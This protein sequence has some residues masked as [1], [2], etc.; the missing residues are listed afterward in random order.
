D[1]ISERYAPGSNSGISIVMR[2]PHPT[3]QAE[4]DS[5]T[6]EKKSGESSSE[7]KSYHVVFM[8]EIDGDTVPFEIQTVTRSQEWKHTLG[9]ASEVLRKTGS[10]PSP[11]RLHDMEHIGKRRQHLI[12]KTFAQQLIPGSLINITK[13]LP[14][15]GSP[16]DRAY[17][18]VE[19]GG[20]RMMVPTEEL[21]GFISDEIDT[22]KFEGD[23]FLPPAE[24]NIEDFMW[25]ISRLDPSLGHSEQ[26]QNALNILINQELPSRH[27]GAPQLEEHL[28]P[29]ALHAALLAANYI[30]NSDIKDSSR[31]LSDTITVA[32]LHDIIEEIEDEEEKVQME[33]QIRD[34]F[35]DEVADSINALT[36]PQEI[37]DPH[38]RRTAYAKQV[39][40]NWMATLVKL[41][42]RA[43]N[44][45]TDLVYLAESDPTDK[46]VRRIYKY[47]VKTLTYFNALF[48]SEKLPPDYREVYKVIMTTAKTIF[49]DLPYEII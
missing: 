28:L 36:S 45:L 5:I 29:T 4:E 8:A 22:G 21:A 40:N 1:I 26:I 41:S 19:S 31:F 23:I 13:N 25:T 27:S 39:E 9:V 18:L 12:D 2:H 24:L 49:P 6:K 35:G 10:Q 11:D 14:D 7:Y 15:I 48:E 17:K 30:R 34:M 42:D 16:V 20:V 38:E 47:F 44:H 3:E 46:Q 33:I 37:E 43:Q 32:L